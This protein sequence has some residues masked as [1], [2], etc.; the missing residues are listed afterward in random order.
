MRIFVGAMA[1]QMLAVRVLEYSIRRHSS[2]PVRVVPLHEALAER[3]LAQ[4]APAD[5]ALRARTPFSFQRF[6]IPELCGF[7]GRAIYLD[8]DMLVFG[9]IATLWQAPMPLPVRAVQ[10]RPWRLRRPQL[11][12]MLLDCARLDW[13]VA[14]L[15]R[16]LDQGQLSYRAIMDGAF[17]GADLARDLAPG[18]NDLEHFCADDTALLH[19]TDMSSQPW[20][21]SSNPLAHL[22]C[23]A[24]L[25]AVAEGFINAADVQ[26]EI[27]RGHVR[28]SLAWQLASGVADPRAV[29]RRERVADR[30][31]FAAPH[32]GSQ[33]P[34][35]RLRAETE[36]L[37]AELGL[38][39]ALASLRRVAM[40]I[41]D[42]LIHAARW[43][44]RRR[45]RV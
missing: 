7:L 9:D 16:R 18:W 27:D 13:R 17:I 24:L 38:R 32:R 43:P 10:A 4:P 25:D 5:P 33:R 21:D 23:Q 1:A 2:L 42:V 26:T 20:L 8:S 11:S 41:A 36:A 12:V 14:A 19:Y 40:H 3:G 29:P 37:V 34:V 28:A 15:T 44:A 39:R 35:G 22:W 30:V 45:P 6:A 31:R